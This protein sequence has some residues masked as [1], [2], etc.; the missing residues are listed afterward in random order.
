MDK[1]I[2]VAV[3]VALVAAAASIA[4]YYFI[5]IVAALIGGGIIFFDRYGGLPQLPAGGD[6]V[7]AERQDNRGSRGSHHESPVEWSR[8]YINGPAAAQAGNL[9]NVSTLSIMGTNVGDEEIKLDEAYFLSDLAGIKLKVQIGRGGGRYNIKDL[10]P[11]PPDAL[12]FAV[13][14]L[15]GSADAGLSPSEFLKTWATISF[16]ARYNGT[17]Q[18]IEFAR[19]TVELALPKQAKP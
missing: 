9:L 11:L 7:R 3:V 16:I 13:S 19:E 12:F 15:L 18:R 14:D 8:L 17:T 10:R 2:V 6:T 4:R 5:A 1:I